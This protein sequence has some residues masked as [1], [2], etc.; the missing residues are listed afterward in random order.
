M[1]VTNNAI[2]YGVSVGPGEPE[3]LTLR[4]VRILRD[5]P[6]LAAPRT[7]GGGTVALDI[8]SGVVDLTDKELL[9]LDFA[10]ARDA[11]ARQ[12]AHAQAAA[13]LRPPLARGL[14]VAVLN[15]GDVSLYGSFPYLARQLAEDFTVEMV[16]GVPSFCAAAARLGISLTRMDQPLHLIPGGVEELAAALPQGTRV[17]MKS[18]RQLGRLLDLLD[19]EGVLDQAML[20]QNCGM[21]QERIFYGV[22]ARQAPPDYFSLVIVPG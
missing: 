18:G 9:T 8:V 1:P 13:Q 17:Y 5:C 2:L 3:L 22:D 21:A 19:R 11:G 14:S 20:V 16:P 6:V 12:A 15:L 7:P 4:A 10:M